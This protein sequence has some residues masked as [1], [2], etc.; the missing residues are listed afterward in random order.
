MKPKTRKPNKTPTA[1]R[2]AHLAAH[3]S[4]RIRRDHGDEHIA[5]LLASLADK[6]KSALDDAN[7]ISRFQAH[8]DTV[9]AHGRAIAVNALVEIQDHIDV[10]TYDNDASTL[11]W[12]REKT[13]AVLKILGINS[14][15]KTS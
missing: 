6:L 1:I 10:A 11:A 12:I 13:T 8:V 7:R 3:E 14:T 5:D 2:L 9:N 4:V 15:R